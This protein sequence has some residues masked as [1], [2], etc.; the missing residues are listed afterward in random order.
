MHTP[1]VDGERAQVAVEAA[2]RLDGGAV[3]QLRL[4]RRDGLVRDQVSG[5]R[6]GVRRQGD[7]CRWGT[8]CQRDSISGTHVLEQRL[9]SVR[10]AGMSAGM[11]AKY[12]PHACA[13]SYLA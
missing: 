2:Q 10:S 5:C 8:S 6:R 7:V 9:R 1:V 12:A 11:E 3:V 4:Q 13:A